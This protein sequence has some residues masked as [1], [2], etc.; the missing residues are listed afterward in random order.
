MRPLFKAVVCKTGISLL[1]LAIAS[2][3]MLLGQP[4]AAQDEQL[5]LVGGLLYVSPDQKPIVD[6]VVVLAAGR[7]SAVG[8]RRSVRMPQ[9]I[10][11]IDC[12]GLTVV[13]GLWNSHVHFLQRKWADAATLPAEE[14]DRQL[15]TMLTR[16]GF[17]SVFDTWSMWENTRRLRDRIESGEVP[18]PR[19]RSTGE[20][21]VGTGVAATA[22][23][24]AALGFMDL[25]KFE[26]A[27]IAEPSDAVRASKKLLDAGTDGLKFY[28]ATPG[29]NSVVLPEGAIEAGVKEA[30]QRGKPVFA[31][32]STAAGL[33]AAVR[34]GAD[35]VTHTTPQSGPWDDSVLA[36]MKGARV[37]L[38]PT[39]KLWQYELRHERAS[40]ADG[41]V[42]TAIGQ[43]RAWVTQDGAVLFGTDVG[44]MSEY[45]P[46]EEYVL[47]AEAGLNVQQILT[48]LT[49]APAERFGVSKELGR[50]SPGYRA[51]VAVLRNDPAKDIRA[52]AAVQYTLRD[53]KII[54]RAPH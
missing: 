33:L 28:A 20:A 30:H 1:L 41:F 38:I 34:A 35:V 40:L 31:H 51:D 47:M 21:M 19:I 27:R 48:S 9:G 5:A 7:I 54:Y 45:D 14:L 11:T 29:R 12:S 16:Y 46:S 53:G 15:Q 10:R 44:Y 4:R 23:S 49:T 17:T 43:L 8:T 24:W 52:F 18:G 3:A 2:S 26:M 42:K 22:A 6:G 37:A 32:P 13:P 39:L 50:I 25:E 36:E